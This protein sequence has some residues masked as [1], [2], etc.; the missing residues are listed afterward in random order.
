MKRRVVTVKSVFI[1]SYTA[2]FLPQSADKTAFCN[3][4]IG[5]HWSL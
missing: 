4:Q 1:G 3:R 5:V 2:S